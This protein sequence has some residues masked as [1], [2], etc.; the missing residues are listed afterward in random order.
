[1][2]V[3]PGSGS[4]RRLTTAAA[5]KTNPIIVAVSIASRPHRNVESSVSGF[6][7]VSTVAASGVLST[8]AASAMSWAAM[9]NTIVKMAAAIAS[10]ITSSTTRSRLPSIF[11]PSASCAVPYSF[12]VFLTNTIGKP[13][14]SERAVVSAH[15]RAPSRSG[16]RCHLE[17]R[18]KFEPTSDPSTK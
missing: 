7:T 10:T 3:F 15:H 11:G 2:A 5:A 6:N 4:P 8:T 9:S 13:D 12:A 14:T 16:G 18:P 17:A 1:M